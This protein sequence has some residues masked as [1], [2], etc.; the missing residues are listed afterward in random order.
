MKKLYRYRPLSEFLFKELYYQELYFASYKELNDPFDLSARIEFSFEDEFEVEFLIYFLYKSTISWNEKY[1]DKVKERNSK[2]LV[3]I[4]DENKKQ[5]FRESLVRKFRVIKEHNDHLWLTDVCHVVSNTVNDENIG[6]DFDLSSFIGELNRIT[7]KFLANSSVTCFSETNDDFLMWAHYASKH[8]GICMEFSLVNDGQF[9]YLE[10]GR[11]KLNDENYK[12]RFSKWDTEEFI[13]W[14]GLNKVRYVDIQPFINFYDF[15]PVFENESDCDLIGLSKPWTHRFAHQLQSVFSIKTKPWAYEKEW[16]A[17]EI[18]F[19][20]P[21]EPEARI[22]HFPLEC[23]SGIYFGSRTPE[24]AKNRIFKLFNSMGKSLSYFDADPTSGRDL[25]F[26]TWE[27]F[28][29]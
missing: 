12:Q 5:S 10:R 28:E 8:T 17:I 29:D 15:S 19:D 27:Y 14:G 9:P 3:F 6:F 26:S 20:S 1:S 22:R 4:N 23:L 21:K 24:S 2:L 16:R 18:N 25:N 7:D 11:R 13:K